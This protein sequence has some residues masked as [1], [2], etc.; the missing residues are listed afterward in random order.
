M[1]GRKYYDILSIFQIPMLKFYY[2]PFMQQL[3][4]RTETLNLYMYI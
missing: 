2:H 4:I 1:G 3:Q